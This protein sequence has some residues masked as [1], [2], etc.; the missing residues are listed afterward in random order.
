MTFAATPTT[1]ALA[2]VFAGVAM[3]LLWP[4]LGD[5]SLAWIAAFL[6]V[7][8]LPAHACVVGFNRPQASAAGM[9]DTAL[10]TRIGVWLLA[11]ILAAAAVRLLPI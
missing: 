3:P 9:M 10:L 8:A 2:G 7:I 5:D 6:L 1:A 4:R 11:A